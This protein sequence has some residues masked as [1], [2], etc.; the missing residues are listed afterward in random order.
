MISLALAL[1]A[2]QAPAAVSP[3]P[4]S[5]PAAQVDPAR[6]AIAER[7]VAALVPPGIYARIMSDKMPAMMDAM[8]AQMSGMS[9]ADLGVSGSAAGANGTM[10]QTLTKLDPAYRERMAITN[11][12]MFAEM[13]TIFGRMEPR[14]RA[15]LSR[16]FARKYTAPQLT[17]MATFFATPSGK[18]F[19]NDYLTTFV[20][21]EV[22]SEMMAMTPEL[23][24]AMPAIMKKV[25]AATA[26]LPKPGAA[27]PTQA[28]PNKPAPK[29]KDDE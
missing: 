1:A 24:K 8:T 22:M 20:D 26:H 4:T 29:A 9:A 10:G 19:A 6:L 11:R 23:M 3:A 15:G 2:V 25:D 21:P 28:D 14:L 13:G 7:I 5:P 12:V 27:A 18:A 17:D 16:A